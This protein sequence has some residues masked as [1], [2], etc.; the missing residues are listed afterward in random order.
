[1]PENS[2]MI[3]IVSAEFIVNRTVTF[4][5]PVNA[6]NPDQGFIAESAVVTNASVPSVRLR[7]RAPSC[8]PPLP[9]HTGL[10][11]AHDA[12]VA[13]RTLMLGAKDLQ[14]CQYCA[15]LLNSGWNFV[16]GL[17]ITD[18]GNRVRPGLLRWLRQ[19]PPAHPHSH[20]HVPCL[21]PLAVVALYSLLLRRELGQ[22]V[23]DPITLRVGR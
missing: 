20:A 18:T 5:T 16:T 9:F 10:H 15:H 14:E 11:H 19:R 8:R 12:Q 23:R 13:S 6:S 4:L 21:P 2:R 1:M 17:S 7:A 3:E 22:P